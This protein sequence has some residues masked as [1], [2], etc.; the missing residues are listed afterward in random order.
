[1]A[2]YTQIPYARVPGLDNDL[3]AT[4]SMIERAKVLDRIKQARAEV[5]ER[6]DNY[7][8]ECKK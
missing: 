6:I 2:E 5:E 8:V 1:M 7:F 3:S 4:R